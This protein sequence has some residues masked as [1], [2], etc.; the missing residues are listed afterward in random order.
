MVTRLRPL[1]RKVWRDLWHLRSQMLA[2]AVVMACGIAMFVT[3]R[4]MNQWLRGTQAAY[5]DRYRFAD[6]FASARRAPLAVAASLPPKCLCKKLAA[7]LAMFTSLPTRSLFT[8]ATKS[9][10]LKSMSSTLA[11]SLAA[12]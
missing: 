1:T 5:Y 8:R 6:V 7:R 3:L 12:M 9:S 2:V 4:S 11:L 10:G